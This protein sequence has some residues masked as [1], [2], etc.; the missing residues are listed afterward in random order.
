MLSKK[1]LYILSICSVLTTI[2]IFTILKYTCIFRSHSC[3]STKISLKDTVLAQFDIDVA[4][5]E[6]AKIF[7]TS[8]NNKE[9]FV[10]MT[11]AYYYIFKIPKKV[12]EKYYRDVFHEFSKESSTVISS[13]ESEDSILQ[14]LNKFQEKLDFL[15]SIRH[16]KE[17]YVNAV[18]TIME[19]LVL[20]KKLD[21]GLVNFFLRFI[22]NFDTSL[23]SLL[24]DD[25]KNKLTE[26][27]LKEGVLMLSY[28]EKALIGI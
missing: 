11:K 18:T 1:S 2:F 9:D 10:F 19:G 6:Y 21:V 20:Y 17:T 27:K 4:F 3:A 13:Q 8:L 24:E 22:R 25:L 26:R 12:L 5:K 23:N 15:F 28:I 14:I 16:T 7:D